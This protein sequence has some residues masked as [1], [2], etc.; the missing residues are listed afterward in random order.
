M[1]TIEPNGTPEPSHAAN[2]SMAEGVGTTLPPRSHDEVDDDD[3][4]S[5]R[6]YTH[7]Q[8]EMFSS[9]VQNRK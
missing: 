6:R 8:V 3:I 5:K 1:R 9:I 2:D 4:F 7:L